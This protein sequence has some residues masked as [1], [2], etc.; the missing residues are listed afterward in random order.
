V[1][2]FDGHDV[3]DLTSVV[4][5]VSVV[6]CTCVCFFAILPVT[7]DDTSYSLQHEYLLVTVYI[8]IC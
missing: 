7:V 6:K 1:F 8:Y 2:K 4:V 3:G 5:E